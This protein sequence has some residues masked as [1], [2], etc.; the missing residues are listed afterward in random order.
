MDHFYQNLGGEEFFNYQAL[1]NRMVQRFDNAHF[2]ELGAFKGKSA[3]FMAVEIINSGKNIKFDCIDNWKGNAEHNR[4]KEVIDHTLYETYLKNIEPVKHVINTVSLDSMEAVKLY[5][6][7]SLDFVF[8][9]ASHEYE[10]VKNDIYHWM[11]KVKKGGVLAGHDLNSYPGV[12]KAVE[13]LLRGMFS[14]EGMSF[15]CEVT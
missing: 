8:I 5:A 1:Y 11:K 14:V 7:K 3:V 10:D 6:D 15:I 2:V 4:I 12:T 9:D 13:E